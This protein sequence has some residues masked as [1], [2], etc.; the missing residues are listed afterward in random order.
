MPLTVNTIILS[1]SDLIFISLI[2]F[3][4][5][6]SDGELPTSQTTS[7]SGDRGYI[8]DPEVYGESQG[9][10]HVKGEISAKMDPSSGSWLLV[11][12]FL[13]HKFHAEIPYPRSLLA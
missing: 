9:R 1:L 11:C 5:A 4:G 12:V 8:S 7:D 13:S 6:Q 3:L 2:N 10:H